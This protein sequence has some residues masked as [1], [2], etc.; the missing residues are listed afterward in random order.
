MGESGGTVLD[1]VPGTG[2]LSRPD[3]HKQLSWI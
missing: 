2:G 3:G 1:R